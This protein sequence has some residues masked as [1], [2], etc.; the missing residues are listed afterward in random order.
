MGKNFDDFLATLTEDV[1]LE[2][3]DIANKRV[4]N[5]EQKSD[6]VIELGTTSGMISATMTIELL[7]RY[8]DWLNQ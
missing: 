6:N 1:Y 8:H 4:N 5:L 7:K 2:I 3:A